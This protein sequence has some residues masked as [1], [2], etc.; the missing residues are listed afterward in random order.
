VSERLVQR[1]TT[2]A[3]TVTPVAVQ[4]PDTGERGVFQGDST[5]IS[6]DIGHADQGRSTRDA[7]GRPL[8]RVKGA[9]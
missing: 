7:A 3:V 4:S 1:T 5:C 9:V 6:C 2:M 8:A